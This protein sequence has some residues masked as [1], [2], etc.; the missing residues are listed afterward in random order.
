M[1]KMSA[2]DMAGELDTI[3]GVMQFKRKLLEELDDNISGYTEGSMNQMQY[4][5][6]EYMKIADQEMEQIKEFDAN[7]KTINQEMSGINGI[8]MDGNGNPMIGQ[9]GQPI[10]VPAEAP[11]EPVFDKSTG[12][13]VQFGLDANGNI[14]ADVKKI[15][16]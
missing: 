9:D 4:V 12:Q 2:A 1:N 3:D 14:V 13:L 11:M 10:Q 16:Q 6:Q 8:Y 15:M 7:S 5:T